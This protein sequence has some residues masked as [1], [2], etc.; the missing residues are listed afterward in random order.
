VMSQDP[1]AGE[2]LPKNGRVDITVSNGKETVSVPSVI[3]KS[4]ADAV[5]TLTNA[6]LIAKV[7]RVSSS[8]PVD[9]V[10]GQDP[11]PGK[12]VEKGSPVRIN[13][14]SGPADI[15]VP[16]VIGL[17]FD[18]ASAALQNQGFAVSRKD[19]ESDQAADTVVD[20]SPSGT[21]KPGS[22]ITLSVSKGPKTST[23]P[24]V[25][26]QDE[27]SARD[28]ITASGFKVQVQHQDVTDPGLDGIVLSQN[29]TGGTQKPKGS[30]VTI[31]V[32]RF[33]STEPP[34]PVP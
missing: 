16:S 23:V 18:Q 28:T 32:G 1:A 29:P 34:P 26:S 3:G 33:T 24:D 8:K 22:T 2:K 13:V 15:T 19:V 27:Q 12:T 14:S 21:A 20:Q 11:P 5:S 31:T 10:T 25:T 9:T 4:Q 7:F 30:T 6:G 17:P